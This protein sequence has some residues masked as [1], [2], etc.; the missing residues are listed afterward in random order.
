MPDM[1]AH[2]EDYLDA[3]IRYFPVSWQTGKVANVPLVVTLTLFTASTIMSFEAM[4]RFYFA[5]QNWNRGGS[6]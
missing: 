2:R 3:G 6:S 1:I 5:E 4:R